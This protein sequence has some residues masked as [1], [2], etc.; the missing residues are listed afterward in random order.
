MQGGF[1]NRPLAVVH[2]TLI[3][4]TT[5]SRGVTRDKLHRCGSVSGSVSD[6][7]SN[8]TILDPL[9]DDSFIGYQ[10]RR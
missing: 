3:L 7:A 9:W 6:I 8:V 1:V 10:L 4:T 5:K 2:L